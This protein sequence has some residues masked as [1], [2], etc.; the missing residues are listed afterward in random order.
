VYK[1]LSLITSFV[2]SLLIA[3]YCPTLFPNLK[4]QRGSACQAWSQQ[5]HRQCLLFLLQEASFQCKGT[6]QTLFVF[7]FV[8]IVVVILLIVLVIVVLVV[9]G[10]GE[11]GVSHGKMS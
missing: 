10:F 7:F 1:L 9:V 2:V 6:L 11:M 8:I 3:F 5:L 4:R